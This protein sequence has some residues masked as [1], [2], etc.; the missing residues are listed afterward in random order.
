MWA[1]PVCISVGGPPVLQP[2]STGLPKRGEPRFLS[3]EI[4]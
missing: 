1:S 3:L 4:R 2:G